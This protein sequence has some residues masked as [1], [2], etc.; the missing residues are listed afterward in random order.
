MILEGLY[1]TM[2]NKC[3]TNIQNANLDDVFLD[4]SPPS[5]SLLPL[6]GKC[7]RGGAPFISGANS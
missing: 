6:P 1:F 4:V 2:E 5:P 7:V 3:Y